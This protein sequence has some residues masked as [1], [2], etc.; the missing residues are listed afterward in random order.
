[1][2]V[3]ENETLVD[4]AREH[5]V[6]FEEIRIA[7]PN[8]SIR[9]PQ[10]GTE[11]LIPARRILPDASRE[12]IVINLSEVRPYYYS[13]PGVVETYPISVG[14]EVVVPGPRAFLCASTA[15]GRSP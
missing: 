10:P 7:N 13:G 15:P 9:A 8:G 11:V 4:L 2:R 3:Q 14:R 12:G 6:G 1:M 5:S